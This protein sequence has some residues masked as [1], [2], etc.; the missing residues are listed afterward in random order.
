MANRIDPKIRAIIE[1]D[2]RKSGDS[3]VL[4]FIEEADDPVI[5]AERYLHHPDTGEEPLEV[6]NMFKN[7]LRDPAKDRA[8]RV[9]RQSGKTVHLCIDLLHTAHFDKNAVILVFV[10]NKNLMERMIEIMGN[11]LRNS[12]IEEAFVIGKKKK[13]TKGLEA[14]H[15]HSITAASGGAIRFFLMSNNPDKAR[16]QRGTHIYVDE[17][18]YMPDKAW[19]V[20]TGIVKGNTD[21]HLWASSTP[22]GLEDTWFRN[23]CGRCASPKYTDGSEYHLPTTMEKNWHLIEPRLRELIHDDITWQLEV[24]AEFVE[25]KGAVYKREI[26]DSAFRRARLGDSMPTC[27][28]LRSTL[29]YVK[30]HKFLGV[31]WN[32]PQNGVR[33]VEIAQMWGKPWLVR[34]EKIAYEDYTQLTA[35][36]RIMELHKKHPYTCMSVD[37]GY[38]DTQVE[39]MQSQLLSLGQDPA[40]IINVVDSGKKEEVVLEYDD[41]D[42]GFIRREYLKVRTKVRIVSLLGKYL[43]TE[44]VIPEEEDENREGI[45]KE[46]RNFR[47]KSATR[48]GGFIYSENSHSLSALQINIH[49]Y[50]MFVREL[51]GQQFDYSSATME[52]ANLKDMVTSRRENSMANTMEHTPSRRTIHTRTEGLYGRERPSRRI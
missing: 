48:E 32:N 39:L 22:S 26:V 9:G 23:F 50:D 30:A 1:D 4:H 27:E 33:L 51:M 2:A 45:G 15:D 24:M 3:A 14:Q 25:P 10:P 41:P 40:K 37:S 52:A 5:W 42:T 34:N 17:A 6:K 11:L 28:D 19:P 20:I 35:V 43:E 36:Q 16:G 49:G 7:L 44:L 29:E 21:I 47:R 18:E 8:A 46:I 31:D 13:K 38:G 12:D